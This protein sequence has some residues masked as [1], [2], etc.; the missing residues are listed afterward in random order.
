MDGQSALHLLAWL[1]ALAGSWLLSWCARTE[2]ALV[3]HLRRGDVPGGDKV[4][5]AYAC[6]PT[7]ED[8][9]LQGVRRETK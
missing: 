3:R 4:D 7:R 5:A 2:D 6:V 8:G 1:A 9:L